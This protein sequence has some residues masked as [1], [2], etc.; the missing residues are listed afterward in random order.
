MHYFKK[1]YPVLAE[2]ALRKSIENDPT[3]FAA[4]SNLGNAL[5]DV[6]KFEEAVEVQ[7]AAAKLNP[8]H[9]QTQNNLGAV[10]EAMARHEEAFECFT[11]AFSLDPDYKTA[12]YNLAAVNLRNQNFVEGWTQRESRWQRETNDEWRRISR[13]HGHFG[14]GPVWKAFIYGLNRV[15]VMKLCSL[16]VSMI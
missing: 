4:Y 9:A 5:L 14:T 8:F 3:Y 1:G 7:Q 13:H 11:K 16:L 10:Y 2:S 15:L 12:E 6:E